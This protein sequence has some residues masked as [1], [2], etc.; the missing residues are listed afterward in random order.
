MIVVAVRR[1]LRSLDSEM[2]SLHDLNTNGAFRQ[3]GIPGN[4]SKTGDQANNGNN[5]DQEESQSTA[6]RGAQQMA[7]SVLEPVAASSTLLDGRTD[8]ELAVNSNTN[9]KNAKRM[10]KQESLH[11]SRRT[12]M[13]ILSKFFSYFKI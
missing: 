8:P 9:A 13:Q 4:Q 1:S 6:L 10:R 5:A 11:V 7:K 12:V 3:P 2:E